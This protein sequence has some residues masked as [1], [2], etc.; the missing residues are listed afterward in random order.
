[1]KNFLSVKSKI[2]FLFTLLFIT[3]L[4]VIG[5]YGFSSAKK[6]YIDSAIVLKEGEVS[7]LGDK[8]E[9]ILGIIPQDLQYDSST[10]TL[11]K[12]FIW[13]D[14]QDK[15]RTKKYR[16]ATISLL[17]DYLLHKPI[18]YQI[19]ILDAKGNEQIVLKYNK[20]SKTVER[21]AKENL[22]NK[23]H[24]EYFKKAMAL[25]KGQFYIS[26]MN[27]NIEHRHIERPFTPVVRFATPIVNANG[28]KQGVFVLN[29]NANYILHMIANKYNTDKEKSY[30]Q[31][32]LINKDGYYLYNKDKTKRWAFQL[33]NS[34]NFNKNYPHI[35]QR[36][37]GKEK[38]AFIK[39]DTIYAL[40]KVYPD[41]LKHPQNFWYLVTV[42]KADV[43][44]S[45]LSNF[46]TWFF[47]LLS[48]LLFFGLIVMNKYI[49]K[50]IYPL[51]KVTTQLKLLSQGEIQKEHI[52]Y[53]ANDE[54]GEIVKSS[55]VLVDAIESLTMQANAV[56]NGNLTTNIELL[57]KN[58]QLGIALTQ[59]MQ[60]LQEISN[61]ASR[62]SNGNYDVNI[63]IHDSSDELGIAISNMINYLK[64]IAKLTEK[65][66]SGDI[67]NEYKLKGEEDR[68]GITIANMTTYLHSILQQSNR[69]AQG[70]FSVTIQPQ[71]KND[72]LGLALVS[73]T[74]ILK[75]NSIKNK[76][77]IFLS[78]G[79]GEF[80]DVTSG[81]DD[82]QELSQK[83]ISSLCR[84]IDAA[85]GAFY[86]YEEEKKELHL[87]S[88]FAFTT[89]NSLS[90]IFKVGE[91]VVGQVALEKNSI[92]L[93]N[94]KED[95]FEVQSGT[96]QAKAKEVYTYPLI[97]E[98]QLLGVIEIMSFEHFTQI[99]REY[100]AKTAELFGITLYSAIQNTKI[101]SLLE[102]SQQAYEELQA[103]SEE[104]EES[105]VQMEEQQ[106][107]LTQQAK[108]LNKRQEEMLQAKEEAERA[109]AYKSEFLANM[110]HELRTPLNSIILLSKL[111]KENQNHTLDA[112]DAQKASVINKA[113]QELLLLI[114]DI[115]DLSKIE[116]GNMELEALE[117]NSEEFFSDLEA[118]FSVVAK[119]KNIDFLIEDNF[120]NTFITDKTKLSQVIKNLL[121]NAFKFTKEG[122]VKLSLSLE[123]NM[124][125]FI[126]KDSGIGIPKEK[127][128][129][130]FDAFK[131]V[132]GSIS[133]EFGGTG[134]GLS[135][136]KQIIDLMQGSIEVQSE[137][138]KGASFIVSIP[139]KKGTTKE[140]PHVT[141]TLPTPSFMGEDV[142][143]DEE[144]ATN[145][146]LLQGKNILI[147]DDDSR[148][149][150]ALSA[151]IESMG[152]EV[153]T[154]F[155]GKEALEVLE[156]EEIDLILMDIMMPIMDG[157]KAMQ[158]IKENE[159]DKNIPIIA[160]TAKTASGDKE[161]CLNAGANDYLA[162]PVDTNAFVSI[163]KAWVK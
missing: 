40:N 64:N 23:A 99:E 101:K 141:Q 102:E 10:F 54:V 17:S 32:Y 16:D 11:K 96:T 85:S 106:Q 79:V 86:S 34:F 93:H 120:H 33:G 75:A 48:G 111:L 124:L 95:I 52:V 127:F 61:I 55:A 67:S 105:N 130:I 58:D 115:L 69:I 87:L 113:G 125:Q 91:G 71:S 89:R 65:I 15:E 5:W 129:L 88:S 100:L 80:S 136:S 107:Q 146:D 68:L 21:V 57:G 134:L 22:Q 14:L 163:V 77:D 151:V 13:K 112:D 116:S 117:I 6:A 78:E 154:A 142:K 8:I 126:V 72:E 123:N 73:M 76:N 145:K 119:E 42:T 159:K 83:A 143:D 43:L 97:H 98:E 49:A 121:S 31:F 148:N 20:I 132:D 133:R 158:S 128:G 56:A 104:L 118:L 46:T 81:I 108:E 7:A 45:S 9:G 30:Q 26:Q 12:F 74:N 24:R 18:Y 135:I 160:I 103:Q 94:I 110:S 50:L 147:V 60:K 153:F 138:G 28:R 92:L 59:M 2:F 19:R 47:I 4:G 44:L 114:N 140:M 157:L 137:Y 162:K 84:Y 35:L 53:K 41:K 39:N 149:I 109:S 156:E 139:L 25:H 51:G 29:L 152:G 27:L 144:I 38:V 66:A 90:N 1:M 155:N 63:I 3:S 122:S 36:I 70:D 82:T 37:K 150:F 161:E 131:Q 62:L